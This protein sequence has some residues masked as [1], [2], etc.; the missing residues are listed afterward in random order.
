[1]IKNRLLSNIGIAFLLGVFRILSQ[2]ASA[3]SIVPTSKLQPGL[4]VLVT[5]LSGVGFAN[6]ATQSGI[7]YLSMA[8][9]A[10]I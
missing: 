10:R 9:G 5:T 4:S 8:G 7:T 2:T 1:M 6:E 3:Q